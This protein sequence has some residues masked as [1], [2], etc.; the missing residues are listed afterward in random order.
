MR[1][2]AFQAALTVASQREP[3]T[4]GGTRRRECGRRGHRR[5]PGDCHENRVPQPPLG[6]R[7][8][9]GRGNGRWRNRPGHLRD[10]CKTNRTSK[11]S[12][13]WTSHRAP[14]SL[15]FRRRCFGDFGIRQL[16]WHPQRRWRGRFFAI[17]FGESPGKRHVRR[18][19]ESGRAGT[20]SGRRR[21]ELA[22]ARGRRH[23]SRRH[24]RRVG[25]CFQ[26]VRGRSRAP[27]DGTGRQ[28]VS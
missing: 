20:F 28:P 14:Q 4:D 10:G 23:G 13:V 19:A 11:L 7:A 8:V 22:H 21:R 12:E 6:D 15:S 3:Q 5:R 24:S 25:T 16:H 17:L 9:P 1:L 2:Q 18:P 27:T 26:D